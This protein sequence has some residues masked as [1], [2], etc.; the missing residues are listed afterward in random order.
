[1]VR[2][3]LAAALLVAGAIGAIVGVLAVSQG[4]W[5]GTTGTPPREAVSVETA[6]SPPAVHFGDTLTARAVVVLDPARVDVDSVRLVPRFLS[7]RVAQATRRTQ[8]DGAATTL[9]YTFALECLG[10]GC[11]P[12]RP[13]VALQFPTALLRYR[14]TAGATSRM[15]VAWPQVTVASRLDDADRAEPYA[16]MRADTSPPPASFDVDP[17]AL[18][19]GL[20]AGSA[21]LVLGAAGLIWLAFRRRHAAPV[22]ATP[23]PEPT[24][25]LAKA[26]RLV[27]EIAADGHRPEL[28]RLALQRL[29]TE[30]R[31][32][33][34]DELAESAGRLAWSGGPP[35]PTGASELA[36]RVEREVAEP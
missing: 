34:R 17:D 14:S 29:V 4:W 5:S 20:L 12:G 21:L 6:L 2:L 33:G 19:D 23:R 9:S 7:Y 22:V 30:L 8:D 32:S 26:L 24:D 18:Q 36:D 15:R 13:Q 35:S 10:A 16:H 1:V 27:R 3:R 11:A 28:R 25:P 31:A